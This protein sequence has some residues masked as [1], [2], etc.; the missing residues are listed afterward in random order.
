[1]STDTRALRGT[2]VG[3]GFFA[4]NHLNAWRMVDGVEIVADRSPPVEGPRELCTLMGGVEQLAST[5]RARRRFRGER[6]LGVLAGPIGDLPEN[7]LMGGEFGRAR[8]GQDAGAAARA[9]AAPRGARD[10]R[11]RPGR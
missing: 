4:A 8:V 7:G 10:D 2:L 11:W 3:C 5:G 1:M 6:G 9:V